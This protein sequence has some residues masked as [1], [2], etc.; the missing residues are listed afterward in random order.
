[1]Q[2]YEKN[3][4]L[5]RRMFLL[6]AE[7]MKNRSQIY[8]SRSIIEENRLMILSNYAA[9]FVGNRQIAN[10][11]TDEI[12]KNRNKIL[13]NLFEND[14]LNKANL[15]SKN[16]KAKLDFLNHRTH[17]NN[18]VLTISE[19]MQ[20]INKKLTE[21]NKKILSSNQSILEFNQEQ[22]RINEDL[23]S[24]GEE[25]ANISITENETGENEKLLSSLETRSKLNQEKTKKIIKKTAKNN[26][27]LVRNK[28][29]ISERRDK[30]IS[31][32]EELLNETRI[33]I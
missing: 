16:N 10:N 27:S 12:F 30:L 1:M 19:E 32:T 26:R 4:N 2:K 28:N 17:L 14:K 21:I 24:K 5:E 8:I 20:K 31:N 11:N 29:D 6:E 18:T 13:E 9:A 33:I 25:N 7:I 3:K 22:T 15:I 23:I